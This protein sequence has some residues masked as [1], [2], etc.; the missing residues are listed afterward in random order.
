MN[1]LL[2][3]LLFHPKL[4]PDKKVLSHFHESVPHSNLGHEEY[5]C[6]YKVKAEVEEKADQKA[7]RLSWTLSRCCSQLKEERV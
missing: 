5:V 3:Q 1:H 4:P 7:R 2:L 6:T